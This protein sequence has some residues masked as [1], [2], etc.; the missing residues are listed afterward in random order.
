MDKNKKKRYDKWLQAVKAVADK[1]KVDMDSTIKIISNM[2]DIRDLLSWAE[3][4][5]FIGYYLYK[6]KD[7]KKDPYEHGHLHY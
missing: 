5:E 6:D 2:S 4:E 7:K 3:A 1:Y